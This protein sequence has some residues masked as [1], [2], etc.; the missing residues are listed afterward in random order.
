MIEIS[1]M[2]F[3]NPNVNNLLCYQP[4]FS[5]CFLFP[6]LLALLLTEI[7]FCVTLSVL[8]LYIL[9]N[10]NCWLKYHPC[11]LRTGKGY[12]CH[13]NKGTNDR[14]IIDYKNLSKFHYF[15][16]SKITHIVVVYSLFGSS[17]HICRGFS[18]FSGIDTW[19]SVWKEKFSYEK[20]IK[21]DSL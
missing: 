3:Q 1:Y 10:L 21:E 20:L 14:C 16:C 11:V 13:L 17:G 8:P 4:N 2:N 15:L 9:L 19:K 18:E 6:S 12:W 5:I 7:S